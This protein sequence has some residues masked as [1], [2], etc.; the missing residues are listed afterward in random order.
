[1]LEAWE[2]AFLQAH[3]MNLAKKAPLSAIC[4]CIVNTLVFSSVNI[5]LLFVLFYI[6]LIIIPQQDVPL[7]FSI[8][9]IIL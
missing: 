1:M 4:T 7:L 9:N 5:A 3:R 8:K 6:F 2:E